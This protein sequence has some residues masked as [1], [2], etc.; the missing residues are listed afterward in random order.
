MD[1]DEATEY[2]LEPNTLRTTRFLQEIQLLPRSVPDLYDAWC[3]YDTN[4]SVYHATDHF[5]KIALDVGG[6]AIIDL[7]GDR[8]EAPYVRF[9]FPEDYPWKPPIP[10]FL[11]NT[12]K[13]AV[14]VPSLWSCHKTFLQVVEECVAVVRHKQ[15]MTGATFYLPLSAQCQW[16]L[17]EFKSFPKDLPKYYKN[18]LGVDGR[19]KRWDIGSSVFVNRVEK[20]GITP[21]L[22]LEFVKPLVPCRACFVFGLGYPYSAPMVTLEFGSKTQNMDILDTWWSQQSKRTLLEAI[23]YV[24]KIVT[25]ETLCTLLFYTNDSSLTQA[26]SS[27][28]SLNKRL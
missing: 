19:G 12:D 24:Y 27:V 4:G 16:L 14:V 8:T 28:S 26:R 11:G 7:M 6:V 23:L 21:M 22:E 18:V 2:K 9:Y 10:K 13:H 15:C 5:D 1:P 20:H 17:N 25:D 3:S